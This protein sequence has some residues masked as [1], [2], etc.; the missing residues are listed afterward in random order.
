MQHLPF[1]E[2]LTEAEQKVY[3]LMLEYRS[4]AEIAEMLG[5]TVPTVRQIVH[6]IYQKMGIDHRAN[7]ARLIFLRKVKGVD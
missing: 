2:R 6:S 5:Y 1:R 3:R 4:N 7:Y